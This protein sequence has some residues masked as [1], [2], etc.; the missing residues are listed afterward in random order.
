MWKRISLAAFALFVA[1]GVGSPRIVARA[2]DSPDGVV[3]GQSVIGADDR[4]RIR[5]TTAFPFSAI[6]YLELEDEDGEVIASCTGTFIGPDALLTAGHCLWDAEAEDW[7]SSNIRVIP[8]KNGSAEPF[9]YDYADDWWV[10]DA[11]TETGSTD[12]DWGVIKLADDSL[13][14]KTGWLTVAVLS[15]ETLE[16]V[17]FQPVIVGY[18]GDKPN[19]TMWGLIRPAFLTVADFTL[20]YDI[21][22]APGQSGSAIWSAQQGPNLGKVVGIHSQ[23]G[24]VNSGSRIDQELLDDILQGCHEMGCTIAVDEDPEPTPEPEPGPQLRFKSYSVAVSRD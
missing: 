3:T 24:T 16:A 2:G 23:G 22:T 1:V 15:T 21:D 5:D 11:Y 14:R 8:G 18:P 13:S 9:G 6:A 12:W 10:P 7:T 17:D 20:Y 19:G 4:I